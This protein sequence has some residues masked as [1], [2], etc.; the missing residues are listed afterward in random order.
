M[1]QGSILLIEDDEDDQF[2]I[3]QMLTELGVP[4]RIQFF[5]NGELAMAYLLTMQEQP[6]IILCDV[7][8]PV[9]NGIELRQRIDENPELREK[10]IPFI[11]LTTDAS[12][13]LVETAYKAT[14]QG[15]FKKETAYGKAKEQLRCI[16]S[17]WEHCLH[18]QNIG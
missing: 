9:M 15:F 7:N 13:G 17:Y 10:A 3:Q 11:Y 14:I 5:A 8:M 18:P 6:F 4:N 12:R 16:I 1:Q 2:L